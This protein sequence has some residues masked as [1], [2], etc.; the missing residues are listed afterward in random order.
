MYHLPYVPYSALITLA[1]TT[2]AT[3]KDSPK[4][5]E[6]RISATN[7]PKNSNVV[8]QKNA[9]IPTSGTNVLGWLTA[10]AGGN[11]V[12]MGVDN[13]TE[14]WAIFVNFEANYRLESLILEG[15]S[16]G[17][18]PTNPFGLGLEDT[19]LNDLI[20]FYFSQNGEHVWIRMMVW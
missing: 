11:L 8:L 17:D 10:K 20:N 18:L 2:A 14:M 19:I 13:T 15:D 6:I 12:P 7:L 9:N 16:S 5:L 1:G 4:S 3:T